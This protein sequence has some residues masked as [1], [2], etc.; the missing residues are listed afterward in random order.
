MN[1]N[2]EQLIKRNVVYEGAYT[3]Q[4]MITPK[5]K[6]YL[7]KKD[8]N[9]FF[10]EYCA[11]LHKGGDKFMSGISERPRQFIPVIVDVDIKKVDSK[12]KLTSLYSQD[13]L[14]DVIN[15]YQL[16]IKDLIDNCTDKQLTCVVLEK[17]LYHVQDKSNNIIAKNG[18]HLHFPYVFLSTNDYKD[19]IYPKVCMKLNEEAVFQNM[20]DTQAEN[21]IDK[22]C[23]KTPWLLYGSRKKTTHK[24]YLMS[25]IYNH[26]C[27]KIG[28][29]EAFADYVIYDD[30][31]QPIPLMNT[32]EYYLPMILSTD[33]NYRKISKLKINPP[34]PVQ[35]VLEVRQQNPYQECK[36]VNINF[37]KDLVRIIDAFRAE[38]YSE[39]MEIGWTLYNVTMGSE[40]G[41]NIWCTFSQQCPEKYQE[42]ACREAW[43][44]ME[45]GNKTLGSLRYYAKTD[46]EYEY[47]N[48][49]KKYSKDK[50]VKSISGS[51]NDIA[52]IMYELYGD[53]FV[54]ASIKYK[55]WFKM[56]GNRWKQIDDGVC[57]RKM[58]ST[59]L[60]HYYVEI[61][62]DISEKLGSGL[63]DE[64]GQDKMYASQSTAVVK[65]MLNLKSSP[66]KNHVMNE[67]THE[68][69]DSAFLKTIDSN[70]YLIGFK[71]GVYDLKTNKFRKTRND[72]YIT[73]QMSVPFN[74][75]LTM[76]NQSVL[77]VIDFLKKVFP[78]ESIRNYF[79][80]TS[81][82]VFMGG[83]PN[84]LVQFWS[85]NG[86]NAKSVTQTIFEKMM[87]DYSIKLPTSLITGK[88]TASGA[89]CP[90][91]ARAGNGVRWAVLQEPDKKDVL[92]VGTLK[93]LSGNDTIYARGLYKE[94]M[95]INPMFKIV[96]ICNDP[97][98]LPYNDTATW[99]RIRI[100]PFES[101]FCDDAPE[102]VE[103][104]FKQKKFPKDPYFADKIPGM[105]EAFAWYLLKH[106]ENRKPGPIV[107]PDKVKMATQ[108]YKKQNDIYQQYI[109]E[110]FIQDA[111]SSVSITDVYSEFKDWFK[112]SIPNQSVPIK[113]EVKEHFVTEWGPLVNG[114]KWKGW[115][116]RSIEDDEDDE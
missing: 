43:E 69:Y 86:D 44:K 42:S 97:P 95:E 104:Q 98:K 2:L 47:K 82:D 60:I 46:N 107:E 70:P 65:L 35:R 26:E 100:L 5:S 20:E 61:A 63:N 108:D 91:L 27:K 93:E 105:I 62:K 14:M 41:F 113:N 15:C 75:S 79:L 89:A 96:L 72:D 102:S 99:N 22:C 10:N 4:S 7:N 114:R 81:S 110:T 25:C 21:Y 32:L 49:V 17:D 6:I 53:T 78:D 116:F 16:V 58:I 28:I 23:F 106:R 9:T 101:N 92:N 48:I 54:C 88:R 56:D 111:K 24:P 11:V 40:Q 3:H 39:W 74:Q 29:E 90:E 19:H 85:G 73:M 80:D 103:E 83:N 57:L 84:K 68:F 8:R 1:Q 52:K 13:L 51:H 30:A 12:Q 64:V 33:P 18:F 38:D 31:E 71:N 115:R 45:L 87:G 36:D 94:G 77:N 37:V 112:E 55:Q 76:E 50:I 59:E 66:Y 67:C 109:D 34:A